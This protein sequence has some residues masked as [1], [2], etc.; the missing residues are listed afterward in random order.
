[1]IFVG[2]LCQDDRDRTEASLLVAEK[3]IRS[4]PDNLDEVST[5]SFLLAVMPVI[6][7]R[8]CVCRL[9]WSWSRYYFICKTHTP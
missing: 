9:L 7:L 3:V 2:L 1:M 8:S 4:Q 5:M 6:A